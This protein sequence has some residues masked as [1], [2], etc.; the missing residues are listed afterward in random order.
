MYDQP[1][2]RE[3]TG[4]NTSFT[5]RGDCIQQSLQDILQSHLLIFTF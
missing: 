4:Q 3:S 5:T 1:K 2:N